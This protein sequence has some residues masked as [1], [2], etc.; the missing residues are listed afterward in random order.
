MQEHAEEIIRWVGAGIALIGAFVVSP[1][2][3]RLLFGRAV[4]A[5]VH[6]ARQTKGW[7]ARFIPFLRRDGAVHAGAARGTIRFGSN[8]SAGGYA[9]AGWPP[10]ATTD[11]RIAELK[12]AV[13]RA[14]EMV[15]ETRK[16]MRKSNKALTKKVD[17]LGTRLDGSLSEV[18][19]AL[20]D[21]QRR[22]HETDA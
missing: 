16:E 18:S 17:D 19:E 12:R 11:E 21:L 1:D 9:P 5:A 13:N 22:S 15:S 10:T 3:T 8:L 4:E 6:A 2:G 20:S 7:L 14:L